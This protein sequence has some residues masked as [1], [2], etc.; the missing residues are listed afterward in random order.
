MSIHQRTPRGK[1][2]LRNPLR[3]KSPHSDRTE[4]ARSNTIRHL[5]LRPPTVSILLCSSSKLSAST[6]VISLRVS[7]SSKSLTCLKQGQR[8]TKWLRILKTMPSTGSTQKMS[9]RF[10]KSRSSPGV[11]QLCLPLTF[12]RQAWATRKTRNP[13]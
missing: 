5:R 7:T 2:L 12:T 9:R 11:L 8:L 4:W 13:V 1:S 3:P 6:T 10:R